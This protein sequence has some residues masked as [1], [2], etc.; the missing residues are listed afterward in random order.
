MYDPATGRY[1]RL[2]LGAVRIGGAATVLLLGA[3]LA[4]LRRREGGR[5][6]V[7]PA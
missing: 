2:A 5:R 7:R 6:D 1:S 3:G 4:W